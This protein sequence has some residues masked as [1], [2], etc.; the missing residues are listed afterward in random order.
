MI[1]FFSFMVCRSRCLVFM[2]MIYAY[3]VMLVKLLVLLFY[4]LSEFC[5]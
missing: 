3:D 1:S 2:N 4:V 5:F